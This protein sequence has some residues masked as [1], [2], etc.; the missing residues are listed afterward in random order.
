MHGEDCVLAIIV[1]G[2]PHASAVPSREA[3]EYFAPA[4][5]ARV[6]PDGALT[7]QPVAADAQSGKDSRRLARLKLLAGLQQVALDEL[8]AATP[9]A[10][11]VSSRSWR[12]PL[13][14]WR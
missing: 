5:R 4:L 11:T 13:A 3:E 14:W 8:A 9:P 7:D 1:A 2:E 6:S 10:G 12:Q